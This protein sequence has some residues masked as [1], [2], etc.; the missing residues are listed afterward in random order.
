MKYCQLQQMRMQLGAST[1]ICAHIHT[2]VPVAHRDA[3]LDVAL[4]LKDLL[5]YE[6]CLCRAAVADVPAVGQPH[7]KLTLR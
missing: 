6:C 7:R 3:M 1:Y 5:I 2:D 4:L